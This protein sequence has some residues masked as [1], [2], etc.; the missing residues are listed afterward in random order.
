ME[1][2]DSTTTVAAAASVGQNGTTIYSNAL[3]TNPDMSKAKG[4][5]YID[6][7]M[8]YL[9]PRIVYCLNLATGISSIDDAEQL[10]QV[11]PNPVSD[12]MTIM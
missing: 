11:S 8:N 6:T 12:I 10:I 7:V 1:W 5:A 9:N 3:L 2:F 4:L